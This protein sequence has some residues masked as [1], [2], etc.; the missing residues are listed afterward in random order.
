MEVEPG[1]WAVG[2]R[3]ER[4]EVIE[5][6]QRNIVAFRLALRRSGRHKSL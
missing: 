3:K 2:L 6:L 4:E 1:G 5:A